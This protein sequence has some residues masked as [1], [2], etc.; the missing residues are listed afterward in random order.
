MSASDGAPGQAACRTCRFR[1]HRCLHTYWRGWWTRPI[2]DRREAEVRLCRWPRT[3]CE[4][5]G[6]RWRTGAGGLQTFEIRCAPA[7]QHALLACTHECNSH[8]STV[9]RTQSVRDSS[10]R[11]APIDS[12]GGL[13][14]NVEHVPHAVR[15][16][17]HPIGQLHLVQRIS[18]LASRDDETAGEVTQNTAQQM[19]AGAF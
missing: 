2:F 9:M 4:S 14:V 16:Y 15:A 3:G 17:M 8:L 19:N 11:T 18:T 12:L 5:V 13:P 7:L 1:S 6:E 10:R